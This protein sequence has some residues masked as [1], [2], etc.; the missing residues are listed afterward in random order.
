ML[1]AAKSMLG[2]LQIKV[3][4][5]AQLITIKREDQ[6]EEYSYEQLATIAEQLF[7]WGN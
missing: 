5:A 4:R 2:D 1:S 3:N 7:P 6:I